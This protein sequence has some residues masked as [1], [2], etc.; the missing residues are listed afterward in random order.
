[1]RA[2]PLP[3][4]SRPTGWTLAEILPQPKIEAPKWRKLFGQPKRSD[5]VTTLPRSKQPW[6]MV[7]RDRIRIRTNKAPDNRWPVRPRRKQ[8]RA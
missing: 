6:P 3:L 5:P 1:M 7:L 8:G 4:I 2:R